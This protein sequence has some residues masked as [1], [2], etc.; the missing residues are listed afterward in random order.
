MASSSFSSL[1]DAL[2]QSLAHCLLADRVRLS[3]RLD[4][5]R[6]TANRR[7]PATLRRD[8]EQMEQQA[9]RSRQARQQREAQLPSITYPAELPI[10]AWKDEIIRAVSQHPVV[11]IAGDTGSGKTTQIPKMCLEAGLG[12]QARIAC[13]QPRRVAALSLSR[14]LAEELQVEWGREV[15]CKIRFQDHTAPDTLIKMMTDGILLA[16]IRSDPELLEYDMVIIDEAH[17]RSLNIDF[18]LGYLRLL[19]RRRPDLKLIV[20]SA[21]IDTEAFSRAFDDAPIIQVSGRMFPVA[22]RYWPLEELLE[23]AED[24]SYTEG[25]VAAVEQLLVESRSAGDHHG[26]LLVFMPS[27]SDIHETCDLLE[28]R[29]L[30]YLEVVPLFGRLTA[31]EQQR[32]FAPHDRRR[33]VVATNI[34]ETSLTIP[35]IRFIVDVGLSRISRYN[36]RTLTQRLPIEPVSQSSAQQ[37][38]GRAGRVQEG[39]C[40]RLYSEE[41]FLSR[42]EYTQPEIQ[43]A[44]LAEVILKMLDIDLGDIEGFPFIDPPKPQ[45]IRGGFQLLQELGALDAKRH[46]TRLGNDMARLSIAPT[47]SRMVLQAHAEGALPEVLAI[48][49]GISIQD[50]RERPLERQDEADQMHRQFIHPRSDFLSLL[51]IWNRYHDRLDELKTQS[52]MRKFCRQHFLSFARMREWRDIH[53][54]LTGTLREIGGFR[55][56]TSDSGHVGTYDAIHRSILTGLF[57]NVACHQELNLYRATR[58][59][60]VMVFPG[61][62]LFQ[63]QSKRARAQVAARPPAERSTDGWIIAAEMVETSRLFART[64]AR[65][66]AEWLLDLAGYLCRPSYRDPHW[67]REAGRVLVTETV[68]LH[69]LVVAIRKKGY[70]QVD[71]KLATEIF[72]REAL[73]AEEIDL[74]HPFFEHNCQLRHR[75]ETWQT[76]RRSRD[77]VDLAQVAYDFYDQRLEKV[78]SIHDLNRYIRD[79]PERDRAL[80]MDEKD[81]MGD[82][83]ASLD[84]EAFPDAVAIDGESVTLG[85]AYRPGEED[86]GITVRLPYRLM[87]A[88]DPEVLEWLVPGL[89]EEKITYLLRSLPKSIRKRLLPIPKTARAIAAEIRPTHPS[90]LESLGDF[91]HQHYGLSIRRRDWQPEGMPVHLQMRVEIRGTEDQVVVAGRDLQ[92]LSE[93]M[94]QHDTPAEQ[95]AWDRAVA[96]WERDEVKSWD[97]GDLPERV[98]VT[99]VSGVPVYAYPGLVAGDERWVCLRLH[100]SQA[101]AAEASRDGFCRLCQLAFKDRLSALRRDLDPIRSLGLLVHGLGKAEQIQDEA[102]DHLV[103][104]LFRREEVLPLTRTA[105]DAALEQGRQRL[106]GLPERFLQHLQAVL[107]TRRQILSSQHSYPGLQDDLQRLVPSGFLRRVPFER[108]ADLGRYLKAVA[109]RAERHGLGAA[110]DAQ[111]QDQVQPYEDALQRLQHEGADPGSRRL[112]QLEELRWMVE[113]WRVSVFAQEL[114]TVMPVSPKRLDRKLEEVERSG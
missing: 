72:I 4:H 70:D 52:Q 77:G 21:T 15:G 84:H 12:R 99:D 43:R 58:G 61:S 9:R 18:L 51:N 76:R 87:D 92:G 28:G 93:Q 71:A 22:V 31:A 33:V 86:D 74:H 101:V 94:E 40:V 59:R 8:L 82:V 91:I 109:V 56:E 23:G 25:A 36:P 1:A 37:R 2:E 14:R 95:D 5:L 66:Q 75:I 3:K 29:G 16:E 32:V 85:Y 104:Y 80:F 63:R 89:R 44:N 68:R 30:P 112:A 11:I 49:A 96:R 19:R 38:L 113:E 57:S 17:E 48:A 27:E 34:A 90:F 46:L 107:E 67:S 13:T 47:V 50:P 55:L 26:D 41:D 100:R 79:S 108:L 65:I 62:G 10:T 78:S 102:R 103:D 54:Q 97:F 6:S 35:G 114:G 20:T 69:G 81:L 111:K 98:Q 106:P 7:R 105:F 53:T 42:P 88:V 39:I 60:E 73:V 83:D 110:K 24:L 64:V 45:A